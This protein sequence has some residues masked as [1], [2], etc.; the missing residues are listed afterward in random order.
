MPRDSGLLGKRVGPIVLTLDFVSARSLL[1]SN[2]LV[3]WSLGLLFADDCA[4]TSIVTWPTTKLSEPVSSVRST[5]C[6]SHRSAGVA[7]R[8]LISCRGSGVRRSITREEEDEAM[9]R[10]DQV[11][12]FDEMR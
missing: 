8:S 4:W 5:I 3:E 10:T 2:R 11:G 1:L 12:N 9:A 6:P 7:S